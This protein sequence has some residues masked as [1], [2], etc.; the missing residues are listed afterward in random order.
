MRS[1]STTPAPSHTT[2]IDDRKLPMA[3]LLALATAVF[4]TSLT[5]TLPAGVLPAMSSDLGVGESAMGQS[6][7]IYAIGTALTAIPLSVATAGLRRKRLLLTAMA[8]F[9]AAN[10]VTAVSGNYPLTMVARFVAGVAAGV[11][12]ALLA[13]YAR[14]MVPAHLQGKAIAIVMAGIP[15]ALSL[16]VPAGTFLGDRFG[17][18]VSF[19]AMTVLALVLIAWIVAIVPDQPGQRPDERTPLLRTL[20]IPG[21]A[22]VL[23]VT[24]V[25]VLAHTVLYT[26]IATYLDRLDM[27]GSTDVVLLVFGGASLLSIWVVGAAIHRRLRE[28]TI[29][30]TLL[31]AAAATILAAFSDSHVPVYAAIVLWGLGWGGAPT[32][33]QTAVGEAGG[34]EADAAQAMLVTLWNAAMAGGGVAGAILLDLLGAGS[35]PWSV[36]VLLIPVLAVVLAARAHGFPA[37]HRGADV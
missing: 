21:V 1:R 30:A 9:A 34:A 18:R 28:L 23:F 12:W 33:L 17:W 7:T 5:E 24:L 22:P 13:G 20:A 31:F 25:F 19:W 2:P 14:R 26:Y 16:G 29:A 32:L 3:A 11:A 37:R 10:T 4:V 35:F 6:V 15:I 36:L 8:G 27:G